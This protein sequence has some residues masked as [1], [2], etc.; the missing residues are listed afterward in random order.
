MPRSR[1]SRKR[2]DL[3]VKLDKAGKKAR[4]WETLSELVQ[5]P[6]RRLPVINLSRLNRITT[7]D[8]TIAVAGKVLGG[9]SMDHPVKVA[10]LA[11]SLKAATSI[12]G[13]GGE[14]LSLGELIEKNP[15]GREVKI[16]A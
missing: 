2:R 11:F 3:S 13:A 12:K 8:E 16:V 10:A 7:R 15:D 9:G 6:R 4:A 14:V 1:L 5:R